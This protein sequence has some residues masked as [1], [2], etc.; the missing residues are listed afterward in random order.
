MV[1]LNSWSFSL[2]SSD[3]FLVFYGNDLSLS[4]SLSRFANSTWMKRE[5]VSDFYDSPL[6]EEEQ[7][8]RILCSS[9]FL[10]KLIKAYKNQPFPN[11]LIVVIDGNLTN[12]DKDVTY[13]KCDALNSRSRGWF[14]STHAPNL[15][16]T[17]Y[18]KLSWV[19]NLDELKFVKIAE[20]LGYNKFAIIPKEED[21][22]WSI[23]RKKQ[24]QSGS[25]NKLWKHFELWARDNSPS[26]EALKLLA[27]HSFNQVI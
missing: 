11:R 17:D 25:H 1:E 10:N 7:P 12:K 3:P 27:V 18:S 13:V 9:G 21:D 24:F 22:I 14:L 23:M 16:L 4:L 26:D 8:K 15:G 5:I 20:Q 6:F 2:K 19:R